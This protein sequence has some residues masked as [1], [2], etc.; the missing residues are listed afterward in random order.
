[1][2]TP[3]ERAAIA[4]GAVSAVYGRMLEEDNDEIAIV[5][6][7]TDLLHLAADQELD[8]DEILESVRNHLE[9]ERCRACGQR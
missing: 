6:L 1:M 4:L 7:L 9:A 3:N 8:V 5:D 2:M